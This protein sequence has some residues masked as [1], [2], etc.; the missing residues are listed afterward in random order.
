MALFLLLA[1]PMV[2]LVAIFV[3]L[4]L[5]WQSNIETNTVFALDAVFIDSAITMTGVVAILTLVPAPS[6]FRARLWRRSG[7]RQPTSG[8][9]KC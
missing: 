1:I 3:S 8:K 9:L 5:L 7:H 4:L 2:S 6:K